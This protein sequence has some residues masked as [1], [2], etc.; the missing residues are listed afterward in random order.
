L[1][2]IDRPEAAPTKRQLKKIRNAISPT[3]IVAIEK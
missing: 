3:A 2:G 1:I